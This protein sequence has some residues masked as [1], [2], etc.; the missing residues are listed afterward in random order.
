MT[1]ST[2][3]GAA[4]A[5]FALAACGGAEVELDNGTTIRADATGTGAKAPD[6]LPSFAPL[7]P[8]ATVHNVVLDSQHPA[9]G[10]V[11]YTVKATPDQIYGFYK[12]KAAAG[13]LAIAQEIQQQGSRMMV[14]QGPP[15]MGKDVG[16][17]INIMTSMTSKDHVT[18]S[19]VYGG[20]GG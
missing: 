19:L 10:M 4:L 17:Q 2:T 3:I 20:P 9:K 16:A 8:G 7:Y 11:G 12:D 14:V 6:N 5:L 15:T 13:G 1:K 18:V